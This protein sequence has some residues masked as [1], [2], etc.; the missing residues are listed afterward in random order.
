MIETLI[1]SDIHLG[2]DI[3]KVKLLTSKLQFKLESGQIHKLILLGDIFQDINFKRLK[4]NHWNFISLL[5]KFSDKIEI[6][7]VY[8]NHDEK[9]VDVMSHLVGIE[10]YEKYI[11][12]H[13]GKKCCAIH[14]HQFD[15]SLT[16]FSKIKEYFIEAYLSIQKIK[17]LHKIIAKCIFFG[18]TSLR[19]K[20]RD[21]AIKLAKE[22][23]YDIIFCGHT[24][25]SEKHVEYNIE[26]FNSGCW[27]GDVGT[28][29]IQNDD[30]ILY[31]FD[32]KNDNNLLD[33]K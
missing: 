17:F 6:V 33:F 1:I 15:T 25:I 4:K 31:E 29:V 5:R 20:V 21:G 7:W 3:S 13:N 27:T 26:Y 19:E 9:I 30:T 22:E 2:S 18:E 24:H 23:G 28:M 8:G 10:V 32:T 16:K 12:E 11:W 14:G